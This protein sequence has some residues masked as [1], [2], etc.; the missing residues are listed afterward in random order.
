MG[1]I[2]HEY[3]P[4]RS[5]FEYTIRKNCLPAAKSVVSQEPVALSKQKALESMS[6]CTGWCSIAKGEFL[7]DLVLKHQPK[8]IVEIG[9]W[10]G[11]SLIPMASALKSLGEGIAYGIDP[12]DSLESAIWR[13]DITRSTLASTW[14]EEQTTMELLKKEYFV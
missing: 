4:P 3:T 8:V 10:G 1:L 11:R 7:V 9:V 5:H 13:D 12:W 6:Q 2:S 14:P